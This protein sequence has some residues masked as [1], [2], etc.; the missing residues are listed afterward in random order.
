VIAP[1]VFIPS[2]EAYGL[3]GELTSTIL[4]QAFAAARILPQHLRLA[5]NISPHQLYNQSLAMQVRQASEQVNFPLTRL[6]IEITESALIGN[7]ELARAMAEQLKSMG[8]RL[9]LDDFGTGYSSLRHL[10]VLPFDE[11]KV[12]HTFVQSMLDLRES[13]KI[14]AAVLGLGQS[15]GLSTV[16]E[17]IERK[18]QADMLLRMGCD[19]GQGWYFGRPVD[20]QQLSETV[21][22]RNTDPA[23]A[24]KPVAAES[25]DHW[26]M[27]APQ[28][29][30]QLQ[31]V[32]D[33]APVGLCFL[34]RNLRYVSVNKRLAEMNRL[35]IGAHLGRTMQEVRPDIFASVKQSLLAALAGKFTPDFEVEVPH[36]DQPEQ[37]LNFLASHQP[38]RDEAGEVVGISVAM[39]NITEFR[40]TE[41]ALRESEDTLRRTIELNPQIPWTADPDGMITDFSPRWTALTGFSRE[42]TLG[43][44]WTKA[45][46][47]D[48]LQVALD[49]GIRSL[50]NG[51]PLDVEYRIQ[52]ITEK[53][54]IW[55][56]SRAVP[57]RNAE[58]NIL[59]WYG[60]V[61][62]I[63][64]YKKTVEALR[65][66][67][68]L[69]HAIRNN[70]NGEVIV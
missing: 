35:P 52:H 11:I 54:W 34:D 18:A 48:D 57:H 46:H 7:L 8:V 64:D 38:V 13:R 16:A 53:R 60:M 29:L 62:D 63:D 6:T 4:S 22:N 50:Q 65:A 56:R 40:K 26:G 15:L 47:P 20:L 41:K 37:T 9:A 17:G 30:A 14:V 27:L 1:D 10:Q 44:G 3:I 69:V 51:E 36:P 12:D 59:R 68:E 55:M 61:E 67:Q 49:S 33:G 39:T 70:T 28:R 24:E 42:E 32:Y 66:S 21:K 31:A 23:A 19:C 25:V 58:G 5:I 43:L 45:V 2:A